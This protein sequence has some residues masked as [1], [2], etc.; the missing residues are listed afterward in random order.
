MLRS[1]GRASVLQHE[2]SKVA[3]ESNLELSLDVLSSSGAS[4]I[5]ILSEESQ[6]GGACYI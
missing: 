2:E 3:M 5:F 4:L 1:N 6:R